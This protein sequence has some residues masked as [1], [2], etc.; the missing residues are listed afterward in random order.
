MF[1]GFLDDPEAVCLKY[2]RDVSQERD[3]FSAKRV[4]ILSKYRYISWLFICN[5]AFLLQF[6]RRNVK[7]R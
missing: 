7:F 2:F 4:Q 3:Y 6:C 5:S 1:H